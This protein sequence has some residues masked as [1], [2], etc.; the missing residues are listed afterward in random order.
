MKFLGVIC[1][2]FFITVR[3]LAAC[4][5]GDLVRD[6]NGMAE[7]LMYYYGCATGENDDETQ[8][9]LARAFQRGTGVTPE[10]AKA[11]LFYH[12][13]ADNGNA[14]AQLE[15]AQLLLKLDETPAGRDTVLEYARKM[16]AAF[17]GAGDLFDGALLHPYALL[18][19]AAENPAQK[20]YY[21]TASKT[22]SG[23]A[24]LLQDYQIDP[25]K[26]QTVLQSAS[27]WKQRKMRETARDVMSADA[28][29]KFESAVFPTTGRVDGFARNQAVQDL[30][31]AIQTY[32]K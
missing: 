29:R 31:D 3:A 5:E 14:S 9:M 17:A 13:A 1:V 10:P 27:L 30:R 16:K 20:W 18:M 25:L 8:L 4:P 26:K 23:A 24:V 7:A 22:A 19:L 12:L 6:K 11:L 21:P 15:L 2:C 28:F 32:L